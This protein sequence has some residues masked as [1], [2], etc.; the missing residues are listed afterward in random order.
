MV[1]VIYHPFQPRVLTDEWRT[2]L[3]RSRM[4]WPLPHFPPSPYGP[5]S[6]SS[7]GDTQEDREREITC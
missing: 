2:R 1:D 3:S 6:V 5:P 4:I 7:I